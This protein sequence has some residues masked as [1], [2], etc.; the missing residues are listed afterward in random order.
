MFE[1]AQFFTTTE[2]ENCPSS[3]KANQ[4]TAKSVAEKFIGALT[5]LESARD[6]EPIVTLF[7]DDC[8]L[9]NIAVSNG[10]RGIEGARRFWRQ[11]R[12]TF[13]DV[14]SIFQ[15]E[16]YFDNEAVFEWTTEGKSKNGRKVKYEG[17]SILE[18]N[19][20]KITRFHAYFDQKNLGRQIT[21]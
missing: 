11:Y 18:T 2:I 6:L 8:E 20:E 19:G 16:V 13:K 4:P 1:T 7:A 5:E 3:R 15:N 17:V 14:C 12:D 21:K 9:S 10:F